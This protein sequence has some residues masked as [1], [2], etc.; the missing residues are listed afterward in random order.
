MY[1]LPK[2]AG[3]E[4]LPDEQ[5]SCA[6][7]RGAK[8]FSQNSHNF[9]VMPRVPTLRQLSLA[10]YSNWDIFRGVLKIVLLNMLYMQNMLYQ[11]ARE[12]TSL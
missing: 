5:T 7:T 3:D 11:Y 6:T 4:L 2:V 9:K 10:R 12:R 1:L 8:E